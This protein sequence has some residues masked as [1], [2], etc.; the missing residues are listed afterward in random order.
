MA[1]PGYDENGDPLVKGVISAT[2]VAVGTMSGN[3]DRAARLQTAMRQAVEEAH[4]EGV[5]DPN[6]MNERIQEAYDAFVGSE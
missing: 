3:A 6:E 1:E 4:A 2:G 5:T